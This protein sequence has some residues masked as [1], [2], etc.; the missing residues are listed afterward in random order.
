[1]GGE[2][3]QIFRVKDDHGVEF[4][5]AELK[6]ILLADHVK[7]RPVVVISVAGE[8][9]QGKSFLLCFLLRFLKNNG[10]SDWMEDTD[11][12]L[13]GFQWRPGGTRGTTGI[14]LWDKAFLMTDSNGEEV[15]ILLMD[16]QGTFDSE[17]TMKESVTIFS[18][19][20]M[21]SSVQIYNVMNNIK[22][23]DLQHLQFFA[24]YG[25][26]AQKETESS[27]FQKLLFLVRDWS[28]PKERNF[29]FEGGRLLVA[30]R[31]EVRDGQHAELMQL[32]LSINSCFRDIDGFLMSDPG[33]KVTSNDSFDGRLADIEEPFRKNLAELVPSLLAPENLLIKEINGRKLSCQELM[34]FFKAYVD[35]FKGGNLPMPT[36]MLLATANASNVAAMDKA[37]QCYMS[38]VANRPRRNLSKLREFHRE[39]LAEAQK[40]FND[41]PK[42]G[43][44]AISS[45]TMDV[46]TK[47]LEELFDQLFKEEEELM[48]MEQEEEAKRERE[49]LEEQKREEQ[50]ERERIAEKEKAEAREAE[51][52]KE[53]EA[54]MEREMALQREAAAKQAELEKK[55]EDERA[56][57]RERAL[58]MHVEMQRERR[59]MNERIAE[60][61]ASANESRNNP[62]TRAFRAFGCLLAAPLAAI[63]HPPAAIELIEEIEETLSK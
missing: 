24:E 23:D 47:E 60:L 57:E 20:M 59:E 44:D 40:V 28:W 14:L 9:R 35:V 56:R 22:E 48:K 43:G 63:L 26:L 4:N 52:R 51:V 33:K 21:T 34:I 18:L 7:D 1:M 13:C 16:T 8:Y 54:M 53:R 30:S 19:S 62:L 3:V 6:H 49:R 42:M 17:S 46:L 11:A 29:G 12:P 10:R 55:M 58:E 39:Q 45:T 25:R 61:E 37:R 31:L 38:G 2:P 32:R 27:P 15:A 36:S 41:F 50:R 5:E